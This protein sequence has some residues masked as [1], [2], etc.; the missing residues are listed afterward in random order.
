VWLAQLNK[1]KSFLL[2]F[3][4]KEDLTLPA[5]AATASIRDL[6]DADAPRPGPAAATPAD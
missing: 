3:F 6:A 2:L 4:K 1:D 5:A